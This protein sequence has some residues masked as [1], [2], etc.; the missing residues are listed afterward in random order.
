MTSRSTVTHRELILV[1]LDLT[2][3]FDTADHDILI[4]R[5][6]VSVDLVGPALNWFS[7]YLKER[8][9]YVSIGSFKSPE[10]KIFSEVP[11]GS[12]PGP[13]LF[14]L[15][16]LPLSIIIKKYNISYHSY[17]DGTQLYISLSSDD[18]SPVNKLANCIN[19]I[20]CWMY[21]NLLQLNTDKTEMLTVGPKRQ[22]MYS[23]LA[24]LSLKYSEQVRKL[25]IILD[26]DL[27]FENHIT[28]IT[29]KVFCHLKNIS[30]LRTFISQ[31]DSQKLV[32]AFI[33]SR[34]DYC[35]A[36]FAG[37]SKQSR[38]RLIQ[39]AA[40]R[41][42]TGTRKFEHITP[43][44]KSLQWLPVQYR[45]TFKIFLIVYKALNGLAPQYISH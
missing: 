21:R 24:S 36:L 15:Y 45:I 2:A 39:N 42:L 44:L 23:H 43:L 26:T 3:A 34:L 18:L 12:V 27:S 4:Q 10:T 1:L 25:G 41:V 32:H 22:K 31:T 5:L 33:S 20:N 8:S 30:K 13:L 38:L 40:A 7:S 17:A 11:H 29:R 14:N 35:K 9:F 16:M 19:D 37:L 6:H 28:N